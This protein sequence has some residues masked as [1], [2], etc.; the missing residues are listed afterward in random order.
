MA[1]F[2]AQAPGRRAGLAQVFLNDL[3]EAIAQVRWAREAGL[4]GVLIPGDN[5]TLYDRHL[6]PF[7]GVCVDLDL[8]VHRHV[9]VVSEPAKEFGSAAAAVGAHEIQ[10]WFMRALAHLIF[11]GVFQ[12]FPDLKFVMTET[13]CSWVP[14][15]LRK[16]DYEIQIGR[17]PGTS[18]H[19]VFG[20]A[21]SG[22]DLSATEYF[23]R[24][25]YLGL[26][27]ARPEE[28][29]LRHQIGVDRLT[30]G[31]DY[32]HTEGTFPNTR[33]ALRLLFAD[34][35]EDEVRIM[36]SLSAAR[37]YG[38]DLKFLQAL[39]DRIGPTVEEIATPV[40]PDEL[41]TDSMSLTIGAAVGALAT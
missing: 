15:E 23:R 40:S 34:V 10:F 33:L 36:T 4:A 37:V 24:N 1:D 27:L 6:D 39:A 12:D 20:G 35:P 11:G 5:V 8:P 32:P 29:R 21:A 14:D 18:A 9:L 38:L 31:A 7:W 28:I 2:C 26:S 22:L 17:T 13:G 19:V 16:L 3:D 41:P 25:C 30:W